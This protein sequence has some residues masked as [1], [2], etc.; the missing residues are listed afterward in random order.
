MAH[1]EFDVMKRGEQFNVFLNDLNDF[2]EKCE[3]ICLRLAREKCG[4]LNFSGQR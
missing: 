2:R 3:S 1:E 4:Q